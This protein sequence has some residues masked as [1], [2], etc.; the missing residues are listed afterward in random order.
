MGCP[1]S[2]AG[3]PGHRLGGSDPIP[4][5]SI[6]ETA[7][8]GQSLAN[9]PQECKLIRLAPHPS[10]LNRGWVGLGLCQAQGCPPP[11][12]GK[13]YTGYLFLSWALIRGTGSRVTVTRLC[14]GTFPNPF[15]ESPANCESFREGI[16]G[17]RGTGTSPGAP[18]K[19]LAWESKAQLY[20]F[21]LRGP[22]QCPSVGGSLEKRSAL[23]RRPKYM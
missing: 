21:L 5:L 1:K 19:A 13:G 12:S 11:L 3:C 14:P 17:H 6:P 2:V 8:A 23:G 15:F 16:W 10:L 7:P 22:G 4:K 9:P 18:M 20:P